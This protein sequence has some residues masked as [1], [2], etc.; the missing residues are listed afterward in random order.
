MKALAYEL[1]LTNAHIDTDF[2]THFSVKMSLLNKE[3]GI[4]L[5]RC[6]CLSNLL[7]NIY[8]CY[9]DAMKHVA[10]LVIFDAIEYPVVDI[11]V[12]VALKTVLA[13]FNVIPDI[14]GFSV[15]G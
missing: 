15:E 10:V 2:K 9:R 14:L 6:T 13:K 8:E 11:T 1:H 12:D 7:E 3:V 5:Q 4:K